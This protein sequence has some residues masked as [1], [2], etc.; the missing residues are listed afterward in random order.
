MTLNN[1]KKV[2]ILLADENRNTHY[3]YKKIIENKNN[4]KVNESHDQTPK[5][6][7]KQPVPYEQEFSNG[8]FSKRTAKRM[9][10]KEHNHTN[11]N[12]YIYLFI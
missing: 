6:D 12:K 3:A 1:A 11:S 4:F 2:S 10:N 9:C 8:I 7:I 5:I